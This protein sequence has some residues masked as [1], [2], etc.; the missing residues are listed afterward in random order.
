MMGP[1]KTFAL[2]VYGFGD[3]K[4]IDE[5]REALWKPRSDQPK[6][7]PKGEKRHRQQG[8]EG[9]KSA[10]SAQENSSSSQSSDS[11]DSTSSGESYS[12][13]KDLDTEQD[14]EPKRKK[15]KKSKKD[16]KKERRE[17]QEAQKRESFAR[18]E[19]ATAS[20]LSGTIASILHSI[21]GMEDRLTGPVK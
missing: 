7:Q 11:S 4:R 19:K 18:K 21:E 8:Q 12:D 15:A 6:D 20:R 3:Q 2:T 1:N 13:A 9:G 16:K 17:K 10:S 5:V 14:E